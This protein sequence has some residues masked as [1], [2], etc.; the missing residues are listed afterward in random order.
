MKQNQVDF[1][2]HDQSYI[3]NNKNY[4]YKD[5]IKFLSAGNDYYYY[6]KDYKCLIIITVI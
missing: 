3:E 1:N 4:S 5:Y 6:Y 2:F